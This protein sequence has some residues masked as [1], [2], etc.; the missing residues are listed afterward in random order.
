MTEAALGPRRCEQ[1]GRFLPAGSR[2]TLCSV[3]TASPPGPVATPSTNGGSAS[4]KKP[5]EKA[6]PPPFADAVRPAPGVIIPRPSQLHPDA[7]HPVPKLSAPPPP[8]MPS[9]AHVATAAI[10]AGV[11]PA[12]APAR[13]RKQ[14]EPAKV[15]PAKVKPQKIKPPKQVSFGGPGRMFVWGPRLIVGLA[16][17]LLVGIVVPLLL[18]R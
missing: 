16:V 2:E 13:P 1:C 7:D 4:L 18:S 11:R 15:K 14:A 5:S 9:A 3:C 17:G 8:P 12:A 10:A 6:A